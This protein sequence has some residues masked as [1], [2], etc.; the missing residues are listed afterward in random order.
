MTRPFTVGVT[1]GIGSGK[2]T[3]CR[4]FEA[5]GV[6]VIDADVVAR[7]VVAP[8]TDG[9]SR[10]VTEFGPTVLTPDGQ[11]DRRRLR[12]LV[13]AEPARRERLEAILHPL[14]RAR[15]AGHLTAVQ[16]PYCLL[17]IPLLIEHGGRTYDIDRILVVDC[18]EEVQIA[19]VMARDDLTASEVA[20]IM[21]TQAS[22][23]ARLRAADDIISN[24]TDIDAVRAQVAGLHQ[25]YLARARGTR[26]ADHS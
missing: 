12:R 16:A 2:S 24:A 25:D 7:E 15:I 26:A 21:N 19:R 14:I 13:F 5:L 20:A 22:R 4:E 10:V 3:I 1:G 23:E 11:L 8:G 6:P 18:P 9:L 17:C